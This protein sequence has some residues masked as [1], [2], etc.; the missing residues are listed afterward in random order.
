MDQVDKAQKDL[1]RILSLFN[2]ENKPVTAIS[3]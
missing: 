2:V 3:I 1:E